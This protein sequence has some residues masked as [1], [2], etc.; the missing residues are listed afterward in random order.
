MEKSNELKFSRVIIDTDVL[1]NWLTKENGLW[2]APLKI[3]K[4]AERKK[5]NGV[6]SIT[7]LFELRY[8]LRRKKILSEY[9]IHRFCEELNTYF[10][11]AIPNEGTLLIANNLQSKYPLG[12]FDSILLALAIS[13]KPSIL[14]S[15]DSE[16]L[17]FASFFLKSLTP[18]KFISTYLSY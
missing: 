18:E 9:I 8:V 14:I 17:R 2:E 13:E 7:S 15:R 3:A 6:I 10:N 1:L 16:L 5:I 4:L 11:I 12:P